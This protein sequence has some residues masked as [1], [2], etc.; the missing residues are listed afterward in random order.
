MDF[1]QATTVTQ[2]GQDVYGCLSP[3]SIFGHRG[4]SEALSGEHDRVVRRGPARRRGR[5]RD[6]P[7]PALRSHGRAL[8]R[9][10]AARR[11]RSSRCPYHAMRRARRDDRAPL[12]PRPASPSRDDDD[13]RSE[14]RASGRRRC[15]SRSAAGRD[16]V[17]AS[18]D[19]SVDRRAARAAASTVPLGITV[20]GYDRGRGRLRR[21]GR[22]DVV[23]PELPLRRCADGRV[24]ARRAGSRSCPGRR[25]ASAT[26][27]GC[28]RWDATG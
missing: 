15:S 26:G 20:Y 22:R 27:S 21:A 11:T 1:E 25:T 23:F 24:A 10:R 16:V 2:R 3:S 9:R 6:R 28:A 12:R 5:L 13:P 17:V 4:S 8:P 14:A 19:H 7:P 18:F